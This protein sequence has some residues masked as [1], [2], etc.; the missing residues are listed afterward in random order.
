MGTWG[1][2]LYSD[3]LA[4]DLRGEFR[5]LVAGGLTPDAAVTKLTTEYA[6]SLTDPDEAPVF[7]LTIAHTAWR[8]G[9]PVPRATSEALRVI[10]AGDDL[11]RW[12][13]AKLRQKRMVVLES[14]AA[15]LRSPAPPA[16]SLRVRFV[17]KNDW[18]IGEVVA[19]R[20]SSQSWTLFR[21]IGHYVDTGGRQAVCE[22]LDWVGPSLPDAATITNLP[23][24]SATEPRHASQ[25]LLG[26]PRRKQDVARFV[27]TGVH[28]AP[29]QQLGGFVVLAFPHVDRQ[30]NEIFA[31]A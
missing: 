10:A 19:F 5:D 23:I 27:R 25:F 29:A 8:I 17:A 21:I 26:E 30:L 18:K 20:L 22:T 6:E 24:R 11:R 4:A 9:R 28:C 14:I 31:L 3:D 15:D 1:T 7:W 2:G 13:H 12:D 16:K